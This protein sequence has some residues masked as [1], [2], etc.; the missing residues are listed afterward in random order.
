MARHRL[1][2]NRCEM[3][4]PQAGAVEILPEKPEKLAI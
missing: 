2:L 4:A 1:H 3:Y